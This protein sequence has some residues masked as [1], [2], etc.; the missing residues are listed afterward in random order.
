[1][2]LGNGDITLNAWVEES[3]DL[4]FYIGKSD[5]WDENGRLLKVGRVRISLDPRPSTPLR[6]FEQK[7]DLSTATLHVQ[8][9]EGERAVA[10]RAW[11]DA[12]RPV[13]RVEVD[14]KEPT[15]AVSSIEL[16][17]TSRYVL[18]SLE[19]SDVMFGRKDGD[20]KQVAVTVEPDSVLAPWKGRIGWFH[21]NVASVGPELTA[22]V[23]G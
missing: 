12:N 10:V 6:A 23:Q 8:Y 20:G 3:G 16:W 15:R 7:L 11:V 4:L 17:R 9:G 18:P 13:I 14:G 5:S 2:P 21:H 22:T 19:V 1:M